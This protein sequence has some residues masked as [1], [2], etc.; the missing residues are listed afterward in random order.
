M[1]SGSK[2]RWMTVVAQKIDGVVEEMK[3]GTSGSPTGGNINTRP[4]DQQT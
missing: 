2:K 1:R 3:R 4:E